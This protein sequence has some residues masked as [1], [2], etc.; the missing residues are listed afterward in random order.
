MP[1]RNIVKIYDVDTYYHI[2]NR[3]VDKRKVF[4]DDQDYALFLS[5]FNRYLGEKPD[6]GSQG[7]EYDWLVNDVEVVAFCLMSNHFHLLL[8]QI[9]MDAI[10]KLLRAVCSS[11]VTYFNVKYN[12][13]GTLFQGCFKAVKVDNQT[14]LQ[15]LTRYIHRNPPDYLNWEWSSLDYWLD[16]KSTYWIKP[17]RL[18]DMSPEK[19]LDFIKDEVAYKSTLK[20]ISDIVF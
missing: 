12:R 15:Y 17:Q 11:Y 14:Y 9:E 6:I 19:Y 8:Y 20:E 5:L 7:R 13:V 4:I 2:Y 3:G 10:T 18:N 16:G 1:S